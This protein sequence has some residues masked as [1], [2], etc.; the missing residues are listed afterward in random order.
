[1]AQSG[2]RQDKPWLSY[3]ETHR[4]AHRNTRRDV[5]AHGLCTHACLVHRVALSLERP[6]KPRPCGSR[7]SVSGALSG[8][9]GRGS[10]GRRLTLGRAGSH[11]GG[12]WSFLRGQKVREC[13]PPRAGSHRG[14]HRRRAGADLKAPAVSWS[15]SQLG[16]PHF[17]FGF[18]PRVPAGTGRAAEADPAGRTPHAVRRRPRR[19]RTTPCPRVWRAREQ[20]SA[21]ASVEGGWLHRWATWKR[22]SARGPRSPSSRTLSVTADTTYPM[23]REGASPRGRPPGPV[24]H[25][26]PEKHIRQVPER[27]VLQIT[28]AVPKPSRSAQGEGHLGPAQPAPHRGA[29]RDQVTGCRVGPGWALGQGRDSGG[30]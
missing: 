9:R 22:A 7:T 4:V 17:R 12:A 15:W 29:R 13:L 1:M 25:R 11:A 23:R 27:G 10:W 14:A 21:E 3:T 20:P 16:D 19:Q 28:R 18:C 30:S 5:R 24:S 26:R 6:E 8:G 2:R